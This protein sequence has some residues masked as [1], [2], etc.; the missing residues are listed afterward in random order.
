MIKQ[1]EDDGTYERDHDSLA[2][3][4]ARLVGVRA[5]QVLD[6]TEESMQGYELSDASV[7]AKRR[8]RLL[9]MASVKP[10]HSSPSSA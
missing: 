9:L 6:F 10:V 7:E 8:T 1:G 2:F 3:A 4:I 5:C